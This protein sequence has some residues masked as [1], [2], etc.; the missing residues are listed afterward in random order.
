MIADRLDLGDINTL[1]RTIRASNRLLTPY[2]DRRAKGRQSSAI[3]RP[4]LL[5]P[6]NAGNR[7]PLRRFIEVGTS[8]NMSDTID[9]S[10]TTVLHS[11]VGDGHIDI[12][13]LLI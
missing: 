10:R 6:V 7:A 5:E 2:M 9:H 13:Q 1:V 11:C 12:V 8:V 3:E 4:F